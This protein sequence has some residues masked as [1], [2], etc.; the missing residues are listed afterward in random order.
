MLERLDGYR[1]LQVSDMSGL[2]RALASA[3]AVFQLKRL[4]VQIGEGGGAKGERRRDLG[5]A[6]TR[7]SNA[8]QSGNLANL[9]ELRVT[10][11]VGGLRG[12]RALCAAL[13][14]GNVSRLRSLSVGKGSR[15]VYG[16]A[17]MRSL[18]EAITAESLPNLEKLC[19]F[20]SE[21]TDQCVEALVE[22]WSNPVRSPLKSLL[23]LSF[24]FNP[25]S[26][27]GLTFLPRL[28][29]SGNVPSLRE[30]SFCRCEELDAPGCE[31]PLTDV[32]KRPTRRSPQNLVV[33]GIAWGSE[34]E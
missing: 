25:I 9:E 31:R 34:D 24:E 28:L 27:H 10:G 15:G 18:A 14:S 12:F 2:S 32:V 17:G 11:P 7:L 26:P 4:E 20:R 5:V 6:V 23:D 21:I 1:E 8:M 29:R 22:V 3:G 19:T 30:L 33:R 13:G 16:V